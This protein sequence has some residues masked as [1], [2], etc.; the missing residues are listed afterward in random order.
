MDLDAL[1]GVTNTLIESHKAAIEEEV[2]AQVALLDVKEVETITP[3]IE[4][5]KHE[6]LGGSSASRWVQCPGSVAMCEALPRPPEA[7]V[8]RKGTFAHSL[9]ELC[10]LEFLEHKRSGTDPDIKFKLLAAH[11]PDWLTEEEHSEVI[12]HAQ[13]YRDA[14]FKQLMG[15]SVTGKVWGFEE[16]VYVDKALGMGGSV[17]FWWAG[18]DDR[19]KRALKLCDYKS[20]FLFVDVKLN[21]QLFFYAIGLL[22]KIRKLGKDIDY[23]TLS[24]FQPKHEP[25]YREVNVTVKALEAYEKKLYKAANDVFF[26]KKPK[27]KTG[28]WCGYCPAKGCCPK[29][30]QDLQVRSSLVLVDPNTATLPEPQFVD[31]ERLVNIVLH[32]KEITAYLKKCKQY[33]ILKA[34][35]GNPLPGTKLVSG[36]S[37]RKWKPESN[38]IIQKLE[39]EV[40]APVTQVKL[41]ALTSVERVLKEELGKE[42]AA[43]VLSDLVTQTTPTITLVRETDPRPAVANAQDILDGLDDDDNDD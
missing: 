12:E 16:K 19:A 26:A 20:G 5:S 24:I 22:K 38:L 40:S 36:V 42:R 15:G 3:D 25:Q 43:E 39:A 2:T 8:A 4:E 31:P 21:S 30:K 27:L 1:L 37:R 34:S 23:V 41:L 17:D 29:Y 9:A 13:A 33:A 18:L 32:E 11:K 6:R 7:H 28:A 10:L 35:A 14:V